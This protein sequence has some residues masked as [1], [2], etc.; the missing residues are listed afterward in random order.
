MQHTA[1]RE[2]R[3]AGLPGANSLLAPQARLLSRSIPQ[4]PRLH[5]A[6]A[7]ALRKALH[8]NH[9]PAAAGLCSLSPRPQASCRNPAA[10]VVRR[11]GEDARAKQGTPCGCRACEL[12]A[13]E[14]ARVSSQVRGRSCRWARAGAECLGAARLR[15]S[16]TVCRWQAHVSCGIVPQFDGGGRTCAITQCADVPCSHM[17]QMPCRQS[18]L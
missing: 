2:R 15:E 16:A 5:D 14:N 1:P 8:S 12:Q 17:C 7:H 13:C 9:G 4:P 11:R 3:P 10:V 18:R 6:H